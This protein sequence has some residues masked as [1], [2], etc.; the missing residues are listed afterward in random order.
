[1]ERDDLMR[2]FA[3]LAAENV[4]YV[5]VGGVAMNL[6]GVVRATED[7]DLFVQPDAE[8]VAGVRRALRRL[9]AD[10]DVDGI[11]AEDLAGDYPVVRYVPPEG[12]PVLDLIARLGDRFVF[13]DL[14]SEVRDLG[15]VPV[16]LATP[17]TLYA[18][19]HDTVRPVDRADAERLRDAFGVG[20]DA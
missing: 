7:V 3:A 8:N 6:H 18:M 1:M 5:L 12:R 2:L 14:N 20:T 10:P 17:A 19:K 9:Y 13:G 15:G 11:R 4:A 16:R